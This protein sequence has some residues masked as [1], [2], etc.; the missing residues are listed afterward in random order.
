MISYFVLD[1]IISIMNPILVPGSQRPEKNAAII[2]SPAEIKEL[3]ELF[4]M[5]R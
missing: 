3:S 2:N 1:V 5:R 4:K